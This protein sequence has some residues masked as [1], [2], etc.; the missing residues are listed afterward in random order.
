MARCYSASVRHRYPPELP[1]VWLISDAR[2]DA[3]L[4]AAIDR[5]PRGSGLVFRHYHLPPHE[6]QARF[7]Q[8]RR[9]ARAR[10]HTVVLAGSACEARRWRADGAYGASRRLGRGPAT[11]RLLTVHSLREIGRANRM[12]ADAV[13]LSP[14][15][16]T[17]SHPGTRTLGPMRFRLLARW[18][19]PPVIALGGMTAAK[20]RKLGMQ[21]WA[22]ID[23]LAQPRAHSFSIHS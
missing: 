7:R 3:V 6:R 18:S 17:R 23:G 16:G 4:E 13:L 10:G 8:V 12:R 20:M 22:A 19:L 1:D 11:L 5:L 2:T 9:Q 21:R 15:F 14:V